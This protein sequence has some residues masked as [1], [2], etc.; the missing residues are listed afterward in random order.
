MSP[1]LDSDLH[2]LPAPLPASTTGGS[3]ESENNYA[4]RIENGSFIWE[5]ASDSPVDSNSKLFTGLHGVNLNIKRGSLVAIIGSSVQGNHR[6]LKR[7]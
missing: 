4:V 3:D 1:E 2:A 7:S 6:W 5:T